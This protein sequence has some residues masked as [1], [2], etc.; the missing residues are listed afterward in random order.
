M[1]Q[2][3]TE[4]N[5]EIVELYKSGYTGPEIGKVYG[6]SKERVRQIILATAGSSLAKESRAARKERLRTE[7]WI[8]RNDK[9]I[10][11]AEYRADLQMFREDQIV[12]LYLEGMSMAEV[13]QL[14]FG[15][16]Q[17]P[18]RVWKFLKQEGVDRRKVGRYERI[19]AYNRYPWDEWTDGKWHE[20]VQGC[21]F[22]CRPACFQKLTYEQARRIGRKATA[23]VDGKVVRFCFFVP[24]LQ[25]RPRLKDFTKLG[26]DHE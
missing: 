23:Y 14:V 16:N 15:G 11:A 17:H 13:S 25:R 10:L 20:V 26:A 1:N 7:G 22:E 2:E 12:R 18:G 5:T 19:G 3:N 24:G 8:T 6:L 9:A 4:R 21:E